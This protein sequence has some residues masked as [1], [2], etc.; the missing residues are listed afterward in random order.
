MRSLFMSSTKSIALLATG[1]EIIHGDI[2]NTNAQKISQILF[3]KQISIGQHMVA[4]DSEQEIANSIE[5]LI[6]AHQ[7][8]ITT[9]G[10][11]PT[12][13]D[14]TR[15]AVARA[16]NKD[17]E[18]DQSSWHAIETRLAKY[19]LAYIPE[20]NKQQALFPNGAIIFPNPNGTAAGCLVEDKKTN[21]MIIMLPGPPNECLPMF[22]NYALPE[23]ISRD[24][25]QQK[26]FKHWMLFGVGEGQ[27]AERLENLLKPFPS[28]QPGYRVTFPYLEF[29]L[30]SDNANE[31]EQAV[32]AIESDVLQFT[33]NNKNQ[34]ASELLLE[35]LKNFPEQLYI[36]DLCTGGFLE[37]L[38]RKP[39]LNH[40]L[41]F[42]QPSNKNKSS[43]W[44]LGI[45]GLDN[46]WA[47]NFDQNKTEVTLSLTIP[48]QAT[49]SLTHEI[50]LHN[51]ERP[52]H[53]AAEKAC[54]FLLK[55]IIEKSEV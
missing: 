41:M 30:F 50:N 22:L 8:I 1:D 44:Q 32:K 31:F 52:C 53:V 10:L 9:G 2:L 37:R 19:G 20:S 49:L 21:K 24:F 46:Y 28:C 13:D 38:I 40:K 34:K 11:G 14:R 36:N 33:M 43:Y 26:Y 39:E 4:S 48:N 42:K 3:D 51:N 12:S 23:L 15:F 7:V 16:L 18:F 25:S 54:E 55:K 47:G 5:Y 45:Q 29:K 17:L 27:T 6:N 35:T